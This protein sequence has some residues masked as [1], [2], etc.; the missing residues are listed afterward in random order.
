MFFSRCTRS[1]LFYVFSFFG[2]NENLKKRGLC[3]CEFDERDEMR[4]GLGT[5]TVA[6][7]FC[8]ARHVHTFILGGQGCIVL[9]LATAFR[10]YVR[11]GYVTHGL[12]RTNDAELPSPTHALRRGPGLY[13]ALLQQRKTKLKLAGCLF[14]MALLS[15]L[16][17]VSRSL[18]S[19]AA[20][21]S[22]GS[23]LT[24]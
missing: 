16:A 8:C 18:Y 3:F 15:G 5:V 21:R 19:F 11:V 6:G 17:A 22:S 9:R 12:P 4:W 24:W 1:L 14:V 20:C 23:Y 13:R 7:S 10:A 2:K